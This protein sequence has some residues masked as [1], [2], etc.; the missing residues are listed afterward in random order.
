M[1]VRPMCSAFENVLLERLDMD[2]GYHRQ[3]GEWG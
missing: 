2:I 3:I 1:E